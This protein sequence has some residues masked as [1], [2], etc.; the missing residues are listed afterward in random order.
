M[1][2]RKQ[3]DIREMVKAVCDD[4][5]G[6]KT[7]VKSGDVCE[8]MAVENT[9]GRRSNIGQ[10][11]GELAEEVEWIEVWSDTSPAYVFKLEGDGD[12]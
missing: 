5:R 4:L 3:S 1:A 7:Y 9:R 8:R 10:A 12:G 11:L 2:A 6:E